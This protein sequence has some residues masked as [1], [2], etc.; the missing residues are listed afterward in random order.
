LYGIYFVLKDEHLNKIDMNK[1]L[2]NFF[3]PKTFCIVGASSKEKSIG[4]E[5]LRSIRDYGYTGKVLPVNPKA[6][7]ILGFKCFSSIEEIS[8][9]IDLAMVVVPKAIAEESIDKLLEKEVGSIILV[10]AGFKEVGKE[11]EEAEKRILEKIK[12]VGTRMVGPNCMGI[13]T[14]FKDISLNATFVAEK[15]AIGQT[16]FLSQSGAIGAAILNSLRETDIRFGHFISVGNKADVSENDLLPF[17]EEDERI[18][19]ITFYL[20]S[21]VDGEKF[22]NYFI[23]KRIRKPVIVLKAGRTKSGMIAAQSHTG[24]L[25]SSDRVVE[26]VLEQFGIIRAETLDELFNSAKGFENFPLPAGNKVAVITNAGGPAILAVDALDKFGL[27]LARLSDITKNK[28]REIVHPEGSVNNPVDLL[29]GGTADQFRLV[30]EIVISDEAVDAVVSV[31]VEPVMVPAL[32]VI[33]G[34]N[35]VKSNK[36]LFQVVMPLPEFWE[37]YRRNSATKKP[38]F[39]K[40]EDPAKVLSDMLF[41]V[42]N[43]N[44]NKS[45]KQSKNN[46]GLSGEGFLQSIDIEKLT[47]K[48]KL[49]VAKN[50]LIGP[51]KINSDLNKINFPVVVKGIAKTVVH[52]SELDAVKVNIKNKKEFSKAINE[53]KKSLAKRKVKVEEFL[54][55]PFIEG[56]HEILIG[57][58]RDPSFGPM[59]MFGSGG[60][61]VEVFNDTCLKSAYLSNKDIQ[62]MIEKTKIGKILKGVRGEKSFPLSRLKRIIKSSAQ[63]MVDNPEIKEFDFNPLIITQENSVFAVDI[64]IKV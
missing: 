46:I 15:P 1:N 38:L 49:P 33:E 45:L 54:I 48:Y 11:G 53:I 22:I 30:N 47:K 5:L 3:Y 17:W 51:D 2:H 8:E 43:R 52:K 26:S 64:R 35:N 14:T 9:K 42:K 41:Y 20:E 18:K 29:P 59:I 50:I 10:T 63:M 37:N 28:L 27:R 24:A 13:I 39:R 31:F 56:K 34:I 61:Y 55:Q 12:A 4:Y 19:T 32:P 36:P 62:E 21:F 16:A 60:K 40:P 44:K 7:E 25:G 57:G 58:F 23:D 6:K